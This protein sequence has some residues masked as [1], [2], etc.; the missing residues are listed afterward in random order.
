M[1]NDEKTDESGVYFDVDEWNSQIGFKLKAKY[2]LLN[3]HF[4]FYFYNEHLFCFNSLINKS[5]YIH[6]MS[7]IDKHFRCLVDAPI[8]TC[9]RQKD[10]LYL[11]FKHYT[12]IRHTLM[13]ISVNRD[14][15][16]EYLLKNPKRSAEEAL[17]NKFHRCFDFKGLFRFDVDKNYTIENHHSYYDEERQS[18]LIAFNNSKND[19]I[20]LCVFNS[21]WN[22]GDQ[23]IG[24][25]KSV[26]ALFAY[27][28]VDYLVHDV[29]TDK[30]ILFL[31]N[32]NL[33]TNWK[34]GRKI[35]NNPFTKLFV[36]DESSRAQ[37]R[38][39]TFSQKINK[40]RNFNDG[41]LLAQ[42]K[43][44][45]DS[46]N[47][48][49]VIESLD[50]GVIDSRDRENGNISIDSN[51]NKK[52]K[53]DNSFDIICY[54]EIRNAVIVDYENK[55]QLQMVNLKQ[56]MR[57]YKNQDNDKND[58]MALCDKGVFKSRFTVLRINDMINKWY[59]II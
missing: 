41:K 13:K 29:R 18:L 50:C 27:G 20:E 12:T 43:I 32:K 10:I 57:K 40:N 35:D 19:C 3:T 39:S 36:D 6:F 45:Y 37:G 22:K 5:V 24:Y 31:T 34:F 2:H 23:K 25:S 44:Q 30:I 38:I 46:E 48:K 47:D 56:E 33:Y 4:L 9:W 17:E 49:F 53:K 54:D 51:K 42:L 58:E 28:K 7:R 8:I 21:K 1:N 11:I 14:N 15:V 16:R 52:D 59:Q 26:S 55:L